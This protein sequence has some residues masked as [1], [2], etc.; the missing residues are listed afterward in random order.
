VVLTECKY[1]VTTLPPI[2]FAKPPL[3]D[4]SNYAQDQGNNKKGS[5]ELIKGVISLLD[6]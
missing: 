2:P 5:R 6:P 3:Q 4:K 1:L